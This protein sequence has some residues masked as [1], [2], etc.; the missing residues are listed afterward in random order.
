MKFHKQN[1]PSKLGKTEGNLRKVI[2]KD[3]SVQQFMEGIG[4]QL[5]ETDFL[6]TEIKNVFFDTLALLS[7][8]K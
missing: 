6:L 5:R 8:S 7:A 1:R 2:S 3:C 4:L